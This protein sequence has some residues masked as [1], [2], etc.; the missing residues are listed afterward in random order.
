MQNFL[1]NNIYD[2]LLYD[3]LVEQSTYD[4]FSPHDREDILNT[5]LER[6]N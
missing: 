5:A 3:S 2:F 4:G 1:T 6:P